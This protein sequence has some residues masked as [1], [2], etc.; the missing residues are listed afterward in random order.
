M[1]DALWLDP[2][3]HKDGARMAPSVLSLF[4][5]IVG[6]PANQGSQAKALI[7]TIY[8]QCFKRLTNRPWDI[9]YHGKLLRCYP[10]NHSSSRAIYFSA[11]PDYWEMRFILDYLRPGDAFIDVGANAGL[12][13]L[14]ALAVVGDQ[15][16]VHAFEPN[17][18]VASI[19]RESLELNGA[20]NV[21]VHEMGCS[22]RA[23]LAEFLN[24]G[25]DCT[26]HIGAAAA[27]GNPVRVD[28]LDDVLEEIPYA[29]IKLDIE[30]Y[31]IFAIRG[32]SKWTSHGN[33]PVMLVETAGYEKRYG[34]NTTEVINELNSLHYCT[35]YYDPAARQLRPLTRPWEVPVENVLAISKDHLQAVQSRIES[36]PQG[37]RLSD[38]RREP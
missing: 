32:A 29:M 22:D 18:A 3:P 30:G 36:D 12:Y 2:Q 7:R 38:L 23:G 1:R 34:I 19:L 37:S 16:C 31:E 8:W 24:G 13:T 5:E 9:S 28:R 25:D 33:P 21:F 17:S 20:A 15:G 14:L 4:N 11:L 27:T 6:H 10:D 26:A 35:A